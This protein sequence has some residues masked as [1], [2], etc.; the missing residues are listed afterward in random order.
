METEY[1]TTLYD[2]DLMN[3][4]VSVTDRDGGIT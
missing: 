2:Y 3:R 1:G 4:L